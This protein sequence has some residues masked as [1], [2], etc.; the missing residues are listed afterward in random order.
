MS[1]CCT[2]VLYCLTS[3]DLHT[4]DFYPS[5]CITPQ[6]TLIFTLFSRSIFILKLFYSMDI[7]LHAGGSLKRV[8]ETK[9]SGASRVIATIFHAEGDARFLI[10]VCSTC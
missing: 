8:A 4:Y 3:S 2:L 10:F 1:L 6:D 9:R 5:T 7:R